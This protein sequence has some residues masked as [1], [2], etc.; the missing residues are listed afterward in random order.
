MLPSIRERT[1]VITMRRRRLVKILA[2]YADRLPTTT[3]ED[4]LIHL[5]PREAEEIAPYLRL[6]EQIRAAMEPVSP[7]QEFRSKLRDDLVAAKNNIPVADTKASPIW[8][9]RWV[10]VGAAA[11][12]IL[13]VAGVVTAVLL[14]QRSVAHSKL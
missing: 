4:D 3:T 9:N 5:N 13:S 11:G 8:H 12:S 10:L 7:S 1:E 14:H 6:S 2:Q